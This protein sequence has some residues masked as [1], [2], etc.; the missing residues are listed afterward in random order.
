MLSIE[1]IQNVDM[2]NDKDFKIDELIEHVRRMGSMGL[3]EEFKSIR[4]QPIASS[5]DIFK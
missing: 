3:S 2:N 5:Y 1:S 4:W